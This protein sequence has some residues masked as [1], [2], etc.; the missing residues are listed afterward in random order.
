[1]LGKCPENFKQILS[2]IRN[3][4]CTWHVNLKKVRV[5][6]IFLNLKKI[7]GN[8]QKCFSKI[9]DLGN[10]KFQKHLIKYLRFHFK[11]NL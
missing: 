9:L 7:L 4:G 3:I 11:Q 10:Y 2:N 1:M 6:N 5:K 8:E